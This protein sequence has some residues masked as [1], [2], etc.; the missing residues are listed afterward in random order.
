MIFIRHKLYINNVR[1]LKPQNPKFFERLLF[2][3]KY[4]GTKRPKNKKHSWKKKALKASL[5]SPNSSKT[6]R[7]HFFFYVSYS[8]YY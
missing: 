5:K 8:F 3:E 6:L 7:Y 1:V 4:K 2:I